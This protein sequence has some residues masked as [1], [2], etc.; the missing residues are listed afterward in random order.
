MEYL[1]NI[2]GVEMR[3]VGKKKNANLLIVFS[4]ENQFEKELQTEFKIKSKKQRS[5]LSRNSVCLAI[6]LP[7][8]VAALTKQ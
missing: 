4:T 8:R 3:Q 6:L 2:T 1:A 5:R 7:I